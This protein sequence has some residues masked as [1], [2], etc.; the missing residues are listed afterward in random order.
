MA[1]VNKQNDFR[2]NFDTYESPDNNHRIFSLN[3]ASLRLRH[4]TYPALLHDQ[5]GEKFRYGW[6]VLTVV[7]ENCFSNT[8]QPC[9]KI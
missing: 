2:T 7:T 5:Y 3:F 9:V 1:T 6:S 8:C 4:P